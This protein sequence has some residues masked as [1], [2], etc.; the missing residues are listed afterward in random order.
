MCLVTCEGV[1]C[2]AAGAYWGGGAVPWQPPRAVGSGRQAGRLAYGPDAGADSAAGGS[3]RGS[4]IGRTSAFGAGCWRFEP[5]P[6]SCV[7]SG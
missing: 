3:F 7:I 1:R 2:I 6:R 4:S 5:S